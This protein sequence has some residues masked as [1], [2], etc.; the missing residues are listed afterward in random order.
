MSIKHCELG[1]TLP[2]LLAGLVDRAADNLT[3]SE[4]RHLAGFSE[5]AH[6]KIQ[7]LRCVAEGVA[8]LVQNDAYAA[9]PAG[10]FRSPESVSLLL[11]ALADLAAQAEAMLTM[12][13]HADDLMELRA[14][15]AAA[16]S[17]E[18]GKGATL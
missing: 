18:P 5:V 3:Q 8:I 14:I 16:A 6:L 4:L 15:P 17:Q 13:Q 11:L 2:S 12:S 1:S 9:A 7:R 10:N